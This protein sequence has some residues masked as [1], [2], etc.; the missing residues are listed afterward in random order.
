[1]I[2]HVHSMAL[3]TSASQQALTRL[4]MHKELGPTLGSA[5]GADATWCSSKGWERL[6]LARL[7][8]LWMSLTCSSPCTPSQGIGPLGMP[9][10]LDKVAE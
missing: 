4:G 10:D 5:A 7:S 3:L 1:M 9:A 6:M 8:C 2:C